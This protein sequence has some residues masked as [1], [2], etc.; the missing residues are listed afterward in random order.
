MSRR[1]ERTAEIA[2]SIRFPEAEAFL[3]NQSYFNVAI[4]L[5]IPLDMIDELVLVP[6]EFPGN[7]AEEVEARIAEN[8]SRDLESVGVYFQNINPQKEG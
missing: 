8:Y 1:R 6:R 3:G 2:T 5:P 7:L 4:G